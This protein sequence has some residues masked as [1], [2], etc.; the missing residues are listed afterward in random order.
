[1]LRRFLLH[2]L[3]L[4]ALA[5]ALGAPKPAAA[6]AAALRVQPVLVDVTAPGAASTLRLHNTGTK[7]VNVQL[8]VFR[9]TQVEGKE[10]LEPTQDVV[11]SPPALTLAPNGQAAA[12]I[13]RVSKRAVQAEES[14]RLYVD[15]LPDLAQQ[16]ANT[17]S[18]L[19]R[20]SIPV[21]FSH[22]AC[23]RTPSAWSIVADNGSAAI[24]A[25]NSGESRERISSLRIQLPNG[26]NIS[27][28]DGLAGYVLGGSQMR[29]SL[30]AGPF[31]GVES[32]AVSGQTEKGPFQAMARTR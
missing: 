19:V 27:L 20:Q 18:L 6:Q 3:P 5:L 2:L 13:V 11:T 26:E 1:M 8:R 21:F 16:E 10:V 4:L 32:V 23:K 9:W 31:A 22:P 17:V 30:G 14:Y 12:R 24:V 15:Q 29:W 25:E 7:P 28:G